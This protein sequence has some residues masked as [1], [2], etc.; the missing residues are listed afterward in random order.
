MP[1]VMLKDAQD[2]RIAL[3]RS[4]QVAPKG[5]VT[6]DM[7]EQARNVDVRSLIE[8]KHGKVAC[9]FHEDKHPSAYYGARSKRLVCPVCNDTWDSIRL[10]MK[11]QDL[12]FYEA[13]KYLCG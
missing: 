2:E 11:F 1:E 4:L 10:T 3:V 13:V 8:F 9:P 7:V 6:D 12:S 5:D